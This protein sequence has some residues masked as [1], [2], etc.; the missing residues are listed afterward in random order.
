SVQ[1]TARSSLIEA[2]TGDDLVERMLV[3]DRD[4]A[5]LERLR[6]KPWATTLVRDDGFAS[7][8]G[9]ISITRDPTGEVVVKNRAARDLVAAVLKLPGRGFVSF[10]RIRDGQAVKGA[11]G[12]VLSVPLGMTLSYSGL[13]PLNVHWLA[14]AL[15]PVAEGLSA[16]LTALEA[17]SAEVDFWPDDVPVLL[18]QLEGGEGKTRDSGFEIDRD[19]VIV[20]VVGWGGVP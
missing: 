14:S 1:P 8:A 15:D 3:V 6:T 7:L 5:H 2:A 4:G 16:A 11:E 20:R 12:N 19:R 10:A 9:G 17:Q 13:H 18:A